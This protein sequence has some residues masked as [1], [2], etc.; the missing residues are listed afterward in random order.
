MNELVKEAVERYQCPGCV[1]GE[2]IECYKKPE[3]TEQIQCGK[4]VV[5]TMLMPI[6]RIM[7]G[8]PKGFNRYIDN[9]DLCIYE[10]FEVSN[11]KYDKYNVPVWKYLNKYGHTL[12]RGIC[13]RTNNIFIHIFLENCIEKINCIE[14]KNA[15][16]E[17]MD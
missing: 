9:L 11:W 12:V 15:D 14:I 17:E 1:C 16:I 10:K 7:L 2:D 3:F 5:G 13:P 6:G 4:H 8:M